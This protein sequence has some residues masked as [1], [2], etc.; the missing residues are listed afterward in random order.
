MVRAY[1]LIQTDSGKAADVANGMRAIGGVMSTEAVTGPY[2]VIVFVEADDVDA[3]GQL[4]VTAIQ[5]VE[6]I[7]RT[8]TCPVIHL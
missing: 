6:G 1:V 3:L 2:D 5:P 7:V 8:L 4:V